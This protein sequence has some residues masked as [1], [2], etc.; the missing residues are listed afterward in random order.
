M[1]M[2]IEVC[3]VMLTSLNALVGGGVP[4][5]DVVSLNIQ[6]QGS[7]SYLQQFRNN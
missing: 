7:I 2:C 1:V 6:T 3:F 4:S 5:M